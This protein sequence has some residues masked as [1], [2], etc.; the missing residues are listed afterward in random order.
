MKAYK[1]FNADMTCRGFQFEE[2]GEYEEKEA[3]LCEAGFHACEDP[4]DCFSY[5]APAQSVYREV[6]LGKVSD[7]RKDDSKIVGK[8]IKIGAALDIAGICKAHF[9][10]VKER[11]TNENNAEAGKPATAGDSGAATSR[12]SAA[13]G[14]NGIACVRGNGIKVKGGLGA[15]LVICAE[16]EKNYDVKE[17]KAAVVDGE[18]I[19]PDTWYTLKDGE[20]VFCEGCDL[21]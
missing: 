1:G 21:E 3:K 11:C 13:V 4:I 18:N 19:L 7:E 14:N 16:N 10:Y 8:R 20:F 9:E 5:Y 2:G 15:I 17:W 6:E 12:G